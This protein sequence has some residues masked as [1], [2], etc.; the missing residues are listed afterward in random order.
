MTRK[1]RAPA[2]STG[3]VPRKRV[4]THDHDDAAAGEA[5]PGYGDWNDRNRPLPA[6]TLAVGDVVVY[7]KYHLQVTG[8]A[9]SSA[10]HNRG[11]VVGFSDENPDRVRVVWGGDPEPMLLG[12]RV[13]CKPGSRAASDNATRRELGEPPSKGPPETTDEAPPKPACPAPVRVVQFGADA[14]PLVAPLLAAADAA[15]PIVIEPADVDIGC[16]AQAWGKATQH[17]PYAD[18]TP[19]SLRRHARAW[20][21]L[22]RALERLHHAYE[23]AEAARYPSYRQR[24]YQRLAYRPRW[25]GPGP[26][27]WALALG[28]GP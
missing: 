5:S 10:A 20:W 6:P 7:T 1:P 23:R 19:V 3:P 25:S 22:T 2:K 21:H 17:A 13:L 15:V 8:M 18:E 12:R 26:A 24:P 28:G 16:V 27:P 9:H 4:G 11:V 14:A